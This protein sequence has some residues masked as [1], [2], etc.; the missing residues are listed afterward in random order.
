V[1]LRW[2]WH[3][4]RPKY[5]DAARSGAGAPT[6]GDNQ[7]GWLLGTMLPPNSAWDVDIYVAYG[8]P[9][10]P[11]QMRKSTGDPRVGPVRNDADMYLT[12]VSTHRT[13][14]W[15][16]SPEHVVP[17]LPTPDETPNRLMCGAL[18]TQGDGAMYWFIDTI[19]AKEL[20]E[21]WENQIR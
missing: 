13:E 19:T 8:A 18:A 6:I 5:T 20:L 14:K 1:R 17:R 11:M 7:S 10:W 15:D 21:D 2:R 4:Q 9:Y 3:L 12:A 16:P